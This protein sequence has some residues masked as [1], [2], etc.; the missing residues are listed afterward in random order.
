MASSSPPADMNILTLNCWGL[1]YV[2]SLRRERLVQIGHELARTSPQPDIVGLQE[3]W[4]QED[5]QSVRDLTRAFLPYGKFYYSG[6]LGGGLAILSRWP[7]EESSMWRYPL[8]GRPTAFWRGDWYVGKGIACARIRYGSAKK[9]V[10]EV[11]NTHTHA[12]YEH[13]PKDSYLCHRLAQAWEVGKMLRGA[14]ER[15]HIVVALGDF[16]MKPGSLA[17]QIITSL[18]PGMKDSWRVLHP[19]SSLGA[20]YDP[21]EQAR[22]RPIPTADFNIRENGVSSDSVYCTWR[23]TKAERKRLLGPGKPDSSVPPDSIDARGHRLDYVFASEGDEA[24]LDGRWAVTDAKVGMMMRHPELGCSLSDH[25]SVQVTL[26]FRSNPTHHS[27]STEEEEQMPK[28]LHLPSTRT[29]SRNGVIE[30]LPPRSSAGPDSP[31]GVADKERRAISIANGSFLQ[32]PTGSDFRHS[33]ASSPQPYAI[34]ITDS[35]T[36]SPDTNDPQPLPAESYA[37]LLSAIDQYTL[38]ERSQRRWRGNHF[39]LSVFVSIACLVGIWFVDGHAFAAFLL[40]LVSTLNLAAGVVDGLIALLFMGWE[41]KA[42]KEFRWEVVNAKEMAAL[43]AQTSKSA[44]M[45]GNDG[46][47]TINGSHQAVTGR[48][49]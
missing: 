26:G 9:E 21:E 39:F 17:H 37:A 38:R 23:W 28:H 15:G 31:D 49:Q 33:Q 35:Q 27:K 16:N 6:V 25:F 7:I 42:L 46:A 1:K 14:C 34:P 18:A 36:T 22:H 5:Y 12:P 48:E 41:I 47:V 44:A 20:S 4:T 13:G 30:V 3:I 24:S 45:P 2:S 11:F 43:S 29:V 19:D 32:S 40:C 10:V 8:N